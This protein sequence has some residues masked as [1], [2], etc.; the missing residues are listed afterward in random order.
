MFYVHV[1]VQERRDTYCAL[2]ANY[3]RF[4]DVYD[5]Y[6]FSICVYCL[7]VRVLPFG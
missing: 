4:D 2:Q 7:R 5:M 3:I 6:K 1:L